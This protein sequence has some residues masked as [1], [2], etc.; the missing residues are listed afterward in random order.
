MEQER[1]CCVASSIEASRHVAGLD[2]TNPPLRLPHAFQLPPTP[3]EVPSRGHSIHF[4]DFSSASSTSLHAVQSC[5]STTGHLTLHSYRR[6]LSHQDDIV[7]PDGLIGR[8]LRR[9]AGAS[10]LNQTR[11]YRDSSLSSFSPSSSAPSSPPPL[12]FSQSV[13]SQQG[14]QEPEDL[15]GSVCKFPLILSN[16]RRNIAHLCSFVFSL[17]RRAVR[18]AP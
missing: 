7:I 1:D 15:H 2:D 6:Y 9:K 18:G 5:Q 12:S 14:G 13:T 4:H 11:S 8:T 10:N 3:T 16:D 17:S